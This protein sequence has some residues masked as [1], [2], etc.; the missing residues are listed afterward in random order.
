[1]LCDGI[2]VETCCTTY[3][4]KLLYS[5]CIELS[6]EEVGSLLMYFLHNQYLMKTSSE[7]KKSCSSRDLLNKA[8]TVGSNVPSQQGPYL[9]K[10]LAA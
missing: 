7:C 9:V 5:N 4:K 3:V 2:Y 6:F 8:L 1:M 10:I